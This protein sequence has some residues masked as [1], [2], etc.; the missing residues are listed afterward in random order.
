M[1]LRK[2]IAQC[3]VLVAALLPL[4]QASAQQAP[5]VLVR[6]VTNE[7]LEIVRA[8]EALRAGEKHRVM[9]LVDAKVLPHFD[10][11]RMTMLAVGRDWRDASAEQ[12]VRLT[13]AFRTLLVRTYSNALTQYRDQTVASCRLVLLLPTSACRCGPKCIR[14]VRSP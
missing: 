1:S 3:C 5:D 8:D 10:F 2:L 14:A 9:E 4:A 7:V 6:E 11:R 13:E 12:Q